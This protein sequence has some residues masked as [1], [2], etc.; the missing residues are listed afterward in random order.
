MR[1]IALPT[2]ILVT[3]AWAPAAACGELTPDE[4]RQAEALIAQFSARQFAA[5]QAAVDRLIEMGPDVLPL[6]RKTLTETDDA[7]VK[8]RCTM[9]VN[10]IVRKYGL[11]IEDGKVIPL[12]LNGSRITLDVTAMPIREVLDLLAR[13]SGNAPL[14][15]DEVLDRT[16][17][18]KLKDVPY[19]RALDEICRSTGLV[20]T[21]AWSQ[22]P[23]RV[24]V[25]KVPAEDVGAYPGP[26][27]V[28]LEECSRTSTHRRTQRFLADRKSVEPEERTDR[29][30][31]FRARCYIEDRLPVLGM[32]AVFTK[33][34][35]A[36]GVNHVPAGGRLTYV[37]GS[38]TSRLLYLNLQ[39]TPEGI[40]GPMTLEGKLTLEFAIGTRELRIDR[41]FEDDRPAVTDG[42]L[43]LTLAAATR[44]GERVTISVKAATEVPQ[45]ALPSFQNQSGYGLV[46]VDPKGGRHEQVVIRSTSRADGKATVT[47]EFR[48]VP[49][50]AG[51]W[52]LL[53]TRPD[54]TEK[55][56]YPFTLKDVP[57]P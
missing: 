35:A 7:E 6:V 9:T 47:F 53:Y 55:R 8:L 41:V 46:L 17:T 52:T 40:R 11:I 44:D 12:N 3:V 29:S 54:R 5:R 31:T 26:M 13:Q 32:T 24:R 30:L 14:K 4:T 37:S 43:T 27:T 15:A 18:L 23:V 45:S 2:M 16:V 48:N 57:L 50:I 39:D 51:D 36:D 33:A 1:R 19:W 20:W 22:Q 38:R 42:D 25:A 49:E 10:G 56:D 34:L 21:E 28:K